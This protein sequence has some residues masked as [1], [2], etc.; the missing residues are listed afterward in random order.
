M[1][2]IFQLFLCL[3]VSVVALGH[4][5][6]ISLHGEVVEVSDGTTI[7]VKV[8][9]RLIKVHLCGIANLNANNTFE[10][11]AREH[12]GK[13]SLGKSVDVEFIG[14]LR[15]SSVVV[16]VATVE[17]IDLGM[18]MLR[19]GAAAFDEKEG[20]QLPAQLSAL[21][22][23]SE[24]VA[25][26]EA[27]GIWQAVAASTNEG[28]K[29]V[30]RVEE[31]RSLSSEAEAKRINDEAYSLINQS[32]YKAALPRVREALRLDPNLAEAHKNLALIFCDTGRPE[33]GVFEAREAIRLKP[34]LDKSHFVMGHILYLLG[35][36][37]SAVK[38]YS[39]AIRLNP[40]YMK[41]HFNLAFTLTEMGQY[42]RALK[43]YDEA[44]K[45]DPQLADLELNSGWLLY[46]MGKI[47]EAKKR[48]EKVLQMNDPVAALKAE[49]NLRNLNNK[50]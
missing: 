23:E 7:S 26:Q 34:G 40:K 1:R 19:D 38:E 43:A 39:E 33:D 11:V 50:R 46:K 24:R 47:G 16:G 14:L 41:A 17:G 48:W 37:E 5:S 25:R 22:R 12:L 36:Y 3:V 44:R 42:D 45:L 9:Q 49:E 32:N 10:P 31:N 30:T 2:I 8:D 4:A 21:Y 15:Q 20:S 35:D 13:L 28:N 6:A 27:R 18:Q 29:A